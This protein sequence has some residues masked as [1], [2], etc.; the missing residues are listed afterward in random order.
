MIHDIRPVKLR[1]SSSLHMPFFASK[2]VIASLMN[3][4]RFSEIPI[5]TCSYFK[6]KSTPVHG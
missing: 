2:V 4:V 1:T 5:A 6:M 3:N